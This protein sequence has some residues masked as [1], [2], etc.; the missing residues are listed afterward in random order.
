MNF[1]K[2]T[3]PKEVVFVGYGIEEPELG[4]NDFEGLDL[5][6]QAGAGHGWCTN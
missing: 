6:G 1:S 5:E 4:W 3:P 2:S